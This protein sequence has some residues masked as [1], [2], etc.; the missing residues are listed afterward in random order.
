M[1]EVSD[2]P[3]DA[4]VPGCH[5]PFH[6]PHLPPHLPVSQGYSILSSVNP[7]ISLAMLNFF[8]IYFLQAAKQLLNTLQCVS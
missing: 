7:L 3:A 1:E 6:H 4:P 5:L 2:E 8:E